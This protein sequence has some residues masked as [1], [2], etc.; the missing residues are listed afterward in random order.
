MKYIKLF[1]DFGIGDETE[2]GI[3]QDV[4]DKQVEIND[5]WYAK[6][7]IKKG[8]YKKELHNRKRIDPN[9]VISAFVNPIDK[10]SVEYYEKIF[11]SKR[12]NHNLKP[13][14][15]FPDIL[16]KDDIGKTFMN[17]ESV[18]K[19]MVGK[20][21]WILTDGHHRVTAAINTDLPYLETKLELKYLGNE[22]DY[23]E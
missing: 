12:L 15:G 1:E 18:T 9:L 16:N 4:T 8:N 5:K 13:I 2:I 23:I 19:E 20:Y 6:E 21:V 22:E 7:I 11:N 14:L 17:G 3:V 10:N